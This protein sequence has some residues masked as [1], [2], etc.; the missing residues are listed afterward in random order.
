MIVNAL[1]IFLGGKTKENHLLR[2]YIIEKFHFATHQEAVLHL[3]I[4]LSHLKSKLQTSNLVIYTKTWEFTTT[5]A[6]GA[7]LVY[8]NS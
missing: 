7:N 8:K 5:K 6:N 1:L 4:F 2:I 3:F